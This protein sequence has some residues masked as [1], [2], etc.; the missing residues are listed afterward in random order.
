MA[1]S[2]AAESCETPSGPEGSSGKQVSSG[3]R[4][5]AWFELAPESVSG[6]EIDGRR[7]TTHLSHDARM[8]FRCGLRPRR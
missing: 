7:A 8:G 6:M 2:H 4:G 5:S 3:R 1:G